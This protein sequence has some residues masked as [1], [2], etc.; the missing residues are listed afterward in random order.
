[1]GN[2][3]LDEILETSLELDSNPVSAHKL[4]SRMETD[5]LIDIIRHREVLEALVTDS[6]DRKDLEARHV[7]SK[8]IASS[9]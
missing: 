4:G 8:T 1:M 9:L 2:A 3:V 5:E 6:L 7:S